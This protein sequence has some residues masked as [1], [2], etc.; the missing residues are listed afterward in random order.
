MKRLKEKW[1]KLFQ[2]RYGIDELGKCIA[3]ISI[4]LYVLGNVLQNGSI[5]LLSMLGLFIAFYRMMSRQNWDR[6]EENRKYMSYIKLWKLR[7]ENRKYSRI[8]MCKRCGTYIRVPKGKG[9]IQVTC[10]KCG[11]RSIHR[12]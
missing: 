3:V 10:K 6:M 9:K 7:Y 4:C 12:T 5:L 8:Y 1:N 11:D 2:G